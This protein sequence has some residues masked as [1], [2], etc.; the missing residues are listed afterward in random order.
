MVAQEPFEVACDWLLELLE[1]E[2]EPPPSR[3]LKNFLAVLSWVVELVE[4]PEPLVVVVVA[5]AIWLPTKALPTPTEANTA[6]A[7]SAVLTR[8]VRAVARLRAE[9]MSTTVNL[10]TVWFL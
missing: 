5:D 9:V 2:L 6:P 10:A 7:T 1:L 8:R 3:P 4:V